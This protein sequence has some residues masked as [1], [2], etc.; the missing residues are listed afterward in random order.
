MENS[1]QQYQETNLNQTE[2]DLLFKKYIKQN[3]ELFYNSDN[4]INPENISDL[5]CPICFYIFKNPINCS[6][7]KNSHAFCKECIDN[8]LKA[9]NKCPTCKLNF[10][11][12]INPSLNNSLNKLL[13]HC[14][15]KNEGCN[16]I[17]PY[18][19]YLNH[20]TNCKY[21]N[22]KYVCNIMK[23]KYKTKTFEKCGF[24]SDKKEIEKH[25]NLCGFIK[26]YC[27]FCKK[28]ILQ[29][30]LGEHVEKICKF[31]I[32]NYPNGNKYLG[33]KN[34][35]KREGYGILYFPNGCRY[36]GEFKNDM[37]EGYG[38]EYNRN[39]IM[40]EGYFRNNKIEGYGILYY[41]D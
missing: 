25:F 23:Y 31:G 27:I 14:S 24:I 38:K 16:S 28:D 8:F 37:R 41:F 1:N 9:S 34:N 5:I 13:F 26:Y 15:F 3:Q 18:S 2:K 35:N 17:I 22:N 10:E 40:F 21:N 39:N 6:D 12:K 19:E 20:I 4:I 33:F 36:E 11:Y 7:K 30:N 32:I 29:I